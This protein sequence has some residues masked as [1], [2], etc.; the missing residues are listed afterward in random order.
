LIFAEIVFRNFNQ[1]LYVGCAE[2]SGYIFAIAIAWGL[3]FCLY[4]RA[5]VR[6]DIFYRF[7]GHRLQVLLDILS[8]AVLFAFSCILALRASGTVRESLL[9]DAVSLTPLQVT[10]WVP[11]LLWAAGLVFFAAN[12]LFVGLY[13]ILLLLQ[14]RA[15]LA[16]ALFHTEDVA[17]VASDE[18]KAI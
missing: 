7:A 18:S 6:I 3:S 14:G 17:D 4:E 12:C 16:S 11:Q 15:A 13:V 2:I 5:H 9:F 10:L 8:I 1:S